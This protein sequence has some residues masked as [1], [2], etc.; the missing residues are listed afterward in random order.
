MISPIAVV[1]LCWLAR[2]LA[3]IPWSRADSAWAGDWSALC[4]RGPC[5]AKWELSGQLFWADYTPPL[6]MGAPAT[7]SNLCSQMLLSDAFNGHLWSKKILKAARRGNRHF[8]CSTKDWERI[9][10]NV[11]YSRPIFCIMQTSRL[12]SGSRE[13]SV[14]LP[15]SKIARSLQ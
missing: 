8:F 1:S 14:P 11:P 5:L 6:G 4:D 10:N 3:G 15:C 13:L 12:L 2:C 9:V 7:V